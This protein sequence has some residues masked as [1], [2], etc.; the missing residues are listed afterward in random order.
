M[1]LHRASTNLTADEAAT[2]T[3]N[4][5]CFIAACENTTPAVLNAVLG[6]RLLK[7][8][9]KVLP[10]ATADV[11]DAIVT[12]LHRLA[13][14]MM[15]CK[16]ADAFTLLTAAVKVPEWGDELAPVLRLF[17][18]TML[19]E[20]VPAPY[21]VFVAYVDACQRCPSV[22]PQAAHVLRWSTQRTC[23]RWYLAN[24][25]PDTRDKKDKDMKAMSE[26]VTE[27]WAGA[28]TA[29]G[30]EA[31]VVF[32]RAVVEVLKGADEKAAG[33]VHTLTL[34]LAL[35]KD[36][37]GLGA[38][39][40]RVL[41]I[42]EEFD[43][44]PLMLDA[45]QHKAAHA[46]LLATIVVESVDTQPK[47][48]LAA[49]CL[50]ARTISGGHAGVLTSLWFYLLNKTVNDETIA[51]WN[52][53]LRELCSSVGA[54]TV[55]G[56]LVAHCDNVTRSLPKLR[57]LDETNWAALTM[58]PVQL[59]QMLDTLHKAFADNSEDLFRKACADTGY[60]LCTLARVSAHI[61]DTLELSET[62][63][64][65][66]QSWILKM[67]R[68][69]LTPWLT[70]VTKQRYD[71]EL[72]MEST[73]E[74][75]R[76]AFHLVE[77]ERRCCAFSVPNVFSWLDERQQSLEEVDDAL[78]KARAA[79]TALQASGNVAAF[80]WMMCAVLS[81]TT[82]LLS[83]TADIRCEDTTEV[84]D[85]V[86]AEL[87]KDLV[88]PY[89][90]ENS[91]AIDAN[92]ISAITVMSTRLRRL[93]TDNRSHKLSAAPASK[94]ELKALSARA[95]DGSA[96]VHP[97]DVAQWLRA[98]AD[99]DPA[100]AP[101]YRT[102][103]L[104][105]C[106]VL[107][108]QSVR[109]KRVTVLSDDE[110]V[111]MVSRLLQ[112]VVA[113]SGAAQV[114]EQLICA[115]CPMLCSAALCTLSTELCGY[116]KDSASSPGAVVASCRLLQ[117]LFMIG[118]CVE[119]LVQCCIE[120]ACTLRKLLD[121]REG[122]DAMTCAFRYLDL[123]WRVVAASPDSVAVV[124]KLLSK[125][126]KADIADWPMRLEV[127]AL[128]HR[129]GHSHTL[130]DL[131]GALATPIQDIDGLSTAVERTNATTHIV[132]LRPRLAEVV[133][134]GCRTDPSRYTPLMRALAVH[135]QREAKVL[136]AALSALA[137]SHPTSGES[138][139][140]FLGVVTVVLHN[141]NV[142]LSPATLLDVVLYLQRVVG[143][144][145]LPT[146]RPLLASAA[147]VLHALILSRKR[148]ALPLLSSVICVLQ[149]IL[150]GQLSG[151]TAQGDMAQVPW[152]VTL[153]VYRDVSRVSDAQPSDA[154]C[155]LTSA[156][157]ALLPHT[158]LL[159]PHHRN[160]AL[161]LDALLDVYFQTTTDTAPL[162]SEHAL[163]SASAGMLRSVLSEY[164]QLRR[165]DLV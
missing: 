164:Q 48:A 145:S 115:L 9:A 43:A 161:V 27:L 147:R 100:M 96:R 85:G 160:I 151:I 37:C 4:W 51:A 54:S 46:Q 97:E 30:G 124:Q 47:V 60:L 56:A 20:L 39:L 84:V 90:D 104:K 57:A 150:E 35:V 122:I 62:T 136:D 50:D 77:L 2:S 82:Q 165:K 29:E 141:G 158:K 103:I 143:A 83:I 125:V 159:R 131:S 152:L 5:E 163:G 32:T 116:I 112:D 24:D 58:H 162:R 45:T 68:T 40:Q 123:N 129:T 156:L 121:V 99:V 71:N 140:S 36:K 119:D 70:G 98:D 80:G 127:L 155:A 14:L 87:H 52:K 113:G 15:H 31:V 110:A 12:V 11:R 137:T 120:A 19:A 139:E 64:A 41:N 157:R 118:F 128:C 134:E 88:A 76:L 146:S 26:F 92:L 75:A 42:Y 55:L 66:V 25:E 34:W 13:S 69:F 17:H 101:K 111:A 130:S 6:G 59:Q 107:Q 106:L 117:A 16:A 154:R 105:L 67:K 108:S 22:T 133:V 81:H 33:R 38:V 153:R 94:S 148:D 126:L 149:K 132:E 102:H 49:G 44:V 3:K 138:V 135:V 28:S 73:A 79:A 72:P 142:V 61:C 53:I 74:A 10:V 78:S 1:D 63:V 114:T 23:L 65:P 144:A 91:E 21:A 18:Q 8:I 109:A 93:T 7:I 95:F 89:L 86:V